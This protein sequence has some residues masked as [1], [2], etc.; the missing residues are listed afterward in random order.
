MVA[1]RVAVA[2]D[3]NRVSDDKELKVRCRAAL[4]FAPD[5]SPSAQALPIFAD[6]R[7]RATTVVRIGRPRQ[8]QRSRAA[9]VGSLTTGRRATWRA[10]LRRARESLPAVIH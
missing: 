1:L 5:A 2:R 6:V 4:Q 8:R 7:P 10:R 9:V 3:C